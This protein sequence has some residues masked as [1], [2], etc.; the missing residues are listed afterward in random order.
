VKRQPIGN[1]G[2]R[3]GE[4]QFWLHASI[5]GPA[6]SPAQW[7]YWPRR[8]LFG[9]P[10]TLFGS[11]KLFLSWDGLLSFALGLRRGSRGWAFDIGPFA[12]V[13]INALD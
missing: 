9:G 8:F 13:K 12:I 6:V 4:G 10:V 1:C 5:Y 3:T 7:W 2:L 11:P